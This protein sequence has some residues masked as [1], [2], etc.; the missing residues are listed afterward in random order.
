MYLKLLH[1]IVALQVELHDVSK[2]GRPTI[3]CVPILAEGPGGAPTAVELRDALPLG[4]FL[5]P[6]A[7]CKDGLV[8]ATEALEAQEPG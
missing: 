6:I 2:P 3:C 4:A 7:A 1:A 8:A 5:A